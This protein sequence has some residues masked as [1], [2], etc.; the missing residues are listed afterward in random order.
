MVVPSRRNSQHTPTQTSVASIFQ[1]GDLITS[2]RCFEMP[3]G[4]KEDGDLGK[5]RMQGSLW[6][7]FGTSNTW[8]D[9]ENTQSYPR[10]LSKQFFF[11]C[12]MV[13]EGEMF[14]HVLV[15]NDFCFV[16]Q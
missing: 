14:E 15:G 8:E 4:S 5:G 16:V 12:W 2:V 9:L 11:G 3:D 13:F 6:D 1:V 7:D 10:F